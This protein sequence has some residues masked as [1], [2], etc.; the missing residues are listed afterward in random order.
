M[1]RSSINFNDKKITKSDFYKHKK[2]CNI[3]NI[4]ISKILVS[5]KETY[6]KYNT[7]KYFIGHYD[8]DVIKPLYLWPSQMTGYINKVDEN[9]ITMSLVIKNKQLLKHCNKIWKKNENFMKIDLTPKLLMVMMMIN[10]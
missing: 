4:D 2:I 9:K 5:K 3:N 7:C 8:N 6:G 1:S 10:T